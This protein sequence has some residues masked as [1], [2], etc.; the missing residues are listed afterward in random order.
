MRQGYIPA[1]KK[2]SAGKIGRRAFVVSAGVLPAAAA[3]VDSR[4]VARSGWARFVSNRSGAIIRYPAHWTV[5]PAADVNLLYPYQ[6]FALRGGPRPAK[7]DEEFPSLA[8]YPRD[9]IYLWLLHYPDRQVSSFAPE[10]RSFSSYR[11]LSE[12]VSEFA[13]FARY[14]AAFTGS[15]HTYLLRLWVGQSVSRQSLRELNQSIASI[16]VP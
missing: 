7:S 5:D 15:R 9:A 14:G 11:D 13:G 4:E 10:F 3:M 6:S 2:E 8:S 1:A 12:Q 16:S